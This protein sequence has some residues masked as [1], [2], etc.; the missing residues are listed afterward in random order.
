MRDD[1]TRGVVTVSSSSVVLEYDR[2][3]LRVI[4]T[5]RVH[6]TLRVTANGLQ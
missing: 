4:P 2:E 6:E 5:N 1:L 3:Y